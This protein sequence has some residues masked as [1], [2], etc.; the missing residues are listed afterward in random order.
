MARWDHQL[1][2]ECYD[3]RQPGAPAHSVPGDPGTR[4]C[5]CGLGPARIPYRD[6]PKH[7]RFC[8]FVHPEGAGQAG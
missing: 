8:R 3:A 6:N 7:Y 5:A 4:C 1:C 2:L